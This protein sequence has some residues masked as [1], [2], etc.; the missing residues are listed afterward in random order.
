MFGEL[1]LHW[2]SLMQVGAVFA[3]VGGGVFAGLQLS[4]RT[5]SPEATWIVL[6]VGLVAGLGQVFR[7]ANLLDTAFIHFRHA[8][9]VLAGQ[10]PVFNA[11]EHVEGVAALGWTLIIAAAAGLTGLEIPTVALVLCLVSYVAL[12][13]LAL[14][15]GQGLW[16]RDGERVYLPFAAMLI[17][18]QGTI[19]PFGTSGM[20]TAT[21]AL[22]TLGA[23]SA[24]VSRRF[25]WAGGL[26]V[27]ATLLRPDHGVFW[28]AGL[29]VVALRSRQ[30]LVR[31][32]L[33]AIAW[34]FFAAFKLWFYGSLVPNPFWALDANT[35]PV[36]QGLWRLM[37]LVMGEHLW[38]LVGL[39]GAWWLAAVPEDEDDLRR[40]ATLGVL[41]HVAAVTAMGASKGYGQVYVTDLVLLIFGAEAVLHHRPRIQGAVAAGLLGAT[42]GGLP[43]IP[44][45]THRFD[46]AESHTFF[47]IKG[48]EPVNM[49]HHTQPLGRKFRSVRDAGG[50]VTLATCCAVGVLGYNAGVEMIHTEGLTDRHLA[51]TDDVDLDYL[52]SRK[53]DLVRQNWAPRYRHLTGVAFNDMPNLDGLWHVFRYDKSRIDDLRAHGRGIAII[54]FDKHLDAYVAQLKG[55]GPTQVAQDLAFFDLYYFDHNPEDPRRAVLAAAA[56][57]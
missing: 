15:L 51:R 33:P 50:Q 28:L 23:G 4:R 42:I 32:A 53:V 48:L 5:I 19:T 36:G 16:E 38:V 35:L 57:G 34:V 25:G 44:A 22:A 30:D 37:V 14:R 2:W 12:G 3:L 27:F 26:A 41:L 13:A 56:G 54:D 18:M 1:A 52:R 49:A 31:Y 46:L 45:G 43:M 24:L 40:F 20:E 6:L 21:V 39:F 8:S 11:G 47:A 55:K 29:V 17:L 10:G 7:Q 9:N